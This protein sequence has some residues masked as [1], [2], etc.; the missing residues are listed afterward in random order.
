MSKFPRYHW[1]VTWFCVL[2]TSVL[3]WPAACFADLLGGDFKFNSV[4]RFDDETGDEVPGGIPLGSAGLEATAGVTVGPDGNIYVSSQN[5]GEILFYDGKTGARLPSRLPGGRNGLFAI[6]RTDATPG[7][8]PGPL[9]F[10]PDGDLYVS[11]FGG[12]T[13]RRFHGTTGAELAPAATGFGPPGGLTFAPDGELYVGNFGTSAVIRVRNGVQ[14]P[15]ILSGTGPIL[16]PSS[17]LFVPNGDLLVVS[18]FANQIHRYSSTGVYLGVFAH[19]EPIVPPVDVTNY[20]SEIV[21]DADGNVVVAVLGATNPPDNAG[22]VLR[23]ALQEGMVAGTLLDTLVD[24]YPP[25]SSI[26]WIPA[27]DAVLS[28]FDSDGM[29]DAGDYDKWRADFGKWVAKGGGADGN[30]SGIVDASD[31]V[32]WRRAF[33][34]GD[35][36]ASTAAVPEPSPNLLL[37][38]S[39]WFA[40]SRTMTRR[41]M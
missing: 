12:T 14:T 15:F 22:Q 33:E 28:D 26:A 17:L 5:T 41:G 31:Y 3:I 32:V 1:Y 23:Y 2:S 16:T 6:L 21:F 39:V 7:G 27:P 9:R 25:I 13:V 30:G 10:G 35:A 24:K 18:M 19:I 4:F 34:G 20:P 29:V 37:L 36:P 11:D 8:A 38:L 40:I